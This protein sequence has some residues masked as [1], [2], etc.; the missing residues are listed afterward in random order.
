MTFDPHVAV[1]PQAALDGLP[2]SEV[3]REP[4]TKSES[5]SRVASPQPL[6]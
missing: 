5:R 6:A 3:Q 2:N 4:V 1:N